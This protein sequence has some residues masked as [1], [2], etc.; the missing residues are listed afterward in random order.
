MAWWNDNPFLSGRVR[1]GQDYW[2]GRTPTGSGFQDWYNT[3]EVRDDPDNESAPYGEW[4]RY[5]S[6]SGF[7]GSG[8]LAELARS[9]FNRAQ[10]AFDAAQ[11]SNPGLTWRKF[12][13]RLGPGMLNSYVRSVSPQE[14]GNFTPQQARWIRY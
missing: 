1:Y 11:L 13:T 14:R 12:L 3:P 8:R 2:G 5:I 6:G 4:E 9:Q 10:S 7:G